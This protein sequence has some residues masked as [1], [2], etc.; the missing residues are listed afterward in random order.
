MQRKKDIG[1][2]GF[3]FSHLFCKKFST[4]IKKTGGAFEPPGY[5]ILAMK[6]PKLHF[7]KNV[8]RHTKKRYV[9]PAHWKHDPRNS[10]FRVNYFSATP[11]KTAYPQPVHN[12]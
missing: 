1:Q 8:H 11:R 2:R 12:P 3:V 6:H 5:W 10:A 7:F 9:L 4:R